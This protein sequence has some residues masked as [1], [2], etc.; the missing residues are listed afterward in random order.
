MFNIWPSIF[1]KSL[2]FCKQGK[3]FLENFC[4]YLCFNFY[5]TPLPSKIPAYAS[6]A[7]LQIR[8]YVFKAT[9]RFFIIN[10]KMSSD[11]VTGAPIVIAMI[12]KTR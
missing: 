12:Y 3:H 6:D 1:P 9:L 11:S 5:I 10:S 4:V 8:L 2:Q 7:V